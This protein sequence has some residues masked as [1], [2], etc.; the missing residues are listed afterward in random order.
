MEKIM[1]KFMSP[2]NHLVRERHSKAR[3]TTTCVSPEKPSSRAY[4]RLG[5]IYSIATVVDDL[6]SRARCGLKKQTTE[7]RR[8]AADLLCGWI[9]SCRL[10]VGC[11]RHH[12][13]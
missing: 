6:L 13:A 7:Y 5:G 11:K 3:L 1:S 2:S 8:R 12:A 4:E 9:P 10:V